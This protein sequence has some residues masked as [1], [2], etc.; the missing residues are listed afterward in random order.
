[1]NPTTLSDAIVQEITIDAPAERVFEALTN[2]EQRMKWWGSKD[3]F[4][5][6]Q[7][8]SDLRVG[9]KWM[10]RGI[11][12]GG[13]PFVL[14]GQ[15]REVEPPRLLVFT[16]LPDWYEDATESLVRW[17][18]TESNGVTTVRLTHSGLR[19]EADRT[20]HRGWPQIMDWLKAYAERL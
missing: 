9:G 7:F 2:P 14:I 3:R 1:M 10:M 16:W 13:R 20:N 19:S 11:G 12:M 6:N 5:V 17:E 4:E 15:Y 8:E 18:L